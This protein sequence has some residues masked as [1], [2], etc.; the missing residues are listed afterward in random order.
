MQIF[1]RVQ[2][3]RSHFINMARG[4][5]NSSVRGTVPLA[6]A[7]RQLRAGLG[8]SQTQFARRI[9]GISQQT[10]SDWEKGKRLRQLQLAQRLF[11]LLGSRSSQ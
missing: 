10:V 11:A 9:G 4:R 2:R 8:L 6:N 3:W 7:I 5:K 1:F